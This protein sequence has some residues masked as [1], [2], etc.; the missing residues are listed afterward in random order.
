MGAGVPTLTRG[1]FFMV[2]VP[3]TRQRTRAGRLAI[4]I[5]A[6]VLA[7]AGDASAAS[8]SFSVSPPTPQTL[9]PVTFTSTSTGDIQTYAW[10]LDND[11]HFDDGTTPTVSR[12]FPSSGIYIVQLSATWPGGGGSSYQYVTVTNRLPEASL[13]FFPAKPVAGDVVNFVSTS[14]DPDGSVSSQLWDLDND[15]SFDDATG[16]L[17]SATFPAA[18][19]YAVKLLVVDNNRAQ[20]TATQT[21]EVAAKP[22]TLASPFPVVRLVGKANRTGV[23]ISRF[24]IEA[25]PG[26]S[27]E[28]RCRGKRKGCPRRRQ[29]RRASAGPKANAARVLRFKRFERRYRAGAILQVFVTKPGAIGKFTSFKVRRNKAPR[30]RDLCVLPGARLPSP[31]PGASG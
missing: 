27:V 3:N 12:T 30:R 25:P 24:S 18:G 28:V 11:G 21:V 23:R 15:G 14:R 29:V 1:R 16:N 13:T 9:E 20:A 26:A 5:A 6:F 2:G 31:C 4:L 17:A 22:L 10:D 19:T 8:V 7:G